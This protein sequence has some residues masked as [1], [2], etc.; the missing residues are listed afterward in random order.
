MTGMNQPPNKYVGP[1]NPG[2]IMDP[3]MPPEVQDRV[4]SA[5]TRLAMG[6]ST[7]VA[8]PGR[9]NSLVT[10]R[11]EGSGGLIYEVTS[12]PR[13]NTARPTQN[14]LPPQA[15]Q[16]TTYPRQPQYPQPPGYSQNS[17]G[18]QLGV[19]FGEH[20]FPGGSFGPRGSGSF[21]KPDFTPEQPAYYG[22]PPP[23]RVEDFDGEAPL[24]AGARAESQ[25][26]SPTMPEPA[27]EISG[28]NGAAEGGYDP[29]FST[30]PPTQEVSSRST[31]G[32]MAPAAPT[33]QWPGPGAAAAAAHQATGG[34]TGRFA[35]QRPA[36]QPAEFIDEPPAALLVKPELPDLNF[37]PVARPLHQR[38]TIRE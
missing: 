16:H 36:H 25:R 4:V 2:D 8:L 18:P 6:E 15:P 32:F 29:D 35:E 23:V 31:T 14:A 5:I 7:S 28:A 9:G 30:P 34:N 13:Q 37:D 22:T 11:G 10:L 1:L 19:E 21:A 17:F 20:R 26:L 38:P 27:P 24:F 33:P 12:V 3:S